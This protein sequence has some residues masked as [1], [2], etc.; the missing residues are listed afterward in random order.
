MMS[1]TYNWTLTGLVALLFVG[2]VAA[3]AIA[4][5]RRRIRQGP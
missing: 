4:L 1:M 3:V 2:I 5:Y